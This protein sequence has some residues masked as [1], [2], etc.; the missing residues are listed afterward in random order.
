MPD[1]IEEFRKKSTTVTLGGNAELKC[2]WYDVV[3]QEERYLMGSDVKKL[4]SIGMT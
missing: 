3:I 1:I 2:F 4:K